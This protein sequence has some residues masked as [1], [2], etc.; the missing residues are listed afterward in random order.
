MKKKLSF[1]LVIVLVVALF[2]ILAAAQSESSLSEEYVSE[3]VSEGGYIGIEPLSANFESMRRRV[4]EVLLPDGDVSSVIWRQQDGVLNF[5]STP[6]A[7][8]MFLGGPFF[9]HERPG[10]NVA[11]FSMGGATTNSVPVFGMTHTATPAA[12][13]IVSDRNG[14]THNVLTYHSVSYAVPNV[15]YFMG[16]ALQVNYIQMW[17]DIDETDE[18]TYFG[19]DWRNYIEYLELTNMR[20]V[21]NSDARL[22][23]I[24]FSLLAFE[25]ITLTLECGNFVF[26]LDTATPVPTTAQSI[27]INRTQGHIFQ[28]SFVVSNRY[29]RIA[30]VGDLAVGVH[31]ATVVAETVRRINPAINEFGNFPGGFNNSNPRFGLVYVDSNGHP[32]GYQAGISHGNQ[33]GRPFV[34]GEFDAYRFD[35][36]PHEVRVVKSATP[37]QVEVGQTV[38]YTI[39]VEN[40]GSGTVNDLTLTDEL[41]DDL[42]FLGLG[43]VTITGAPVGSYEVGLPAYNDGIFTLEISRLDAGAVLTVSFDAEVIG[44][45]CEEYNKIR[46]IAV[47]SGDGIGGDEESNENY[48]VVTPP[49]MG[50]GPFITDH[51]SYI[52]GYPDGY[53]RPRNNISRAE[54]ATVYFRLLTDSVRNANWA[55]TN[56]FTDV[57]PRHWHNNAV[58]VMSS[59]NIITGYRDGT[60]RPGEAITRAELAAIAA[61][62]SS[63]MDLTRGETPRFSD[64]TGHWAQDYIMTAAAYGWLTGYPDGSFRPNT[65]IRRAEFMAL[66]NRM[67]GRA[68]RTVNDLLPNE[69]NAWPDNSNHVSWYYLVVQEATN[70]TVPGFHDEMVPGTNFYFKYWAEMLE[71]PN[72][73]YLERIWAANNGR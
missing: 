7:S 11:S 26:V 58:S 46:N 4:V 54:V 34:V 3:A 51:L 21:H 10:F 57:Q 64:I 36:R 5:N 20:A 16:P 72:W 32:I 49:G 66:V 71:D 69:M 62:F 45:G 63:L 65:P 42:E 31:Q 56:D 27:T 28:G 24:D 30:P 13:R 25:P 39:E 9:V 18:S 14:I 37:E 29:V 2:P 33:R 61:R 55:Q 40:I 35:V 52:I 43:Y 44:T 67:L 70:S 6:N 17:I 68:P 19:Y 53:V 60:F 41:N 23:G 47:V 50:D 73:L 38:R 1:A 59:M 22:P 12:Q 48:V 15:F 8:N